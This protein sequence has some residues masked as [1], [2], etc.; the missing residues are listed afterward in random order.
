MKNNK[1]YEFTGKTA[2][3]GKHILHRIRALRDF[4]DVKA[5]DLGGFIESEG[6][7]SHDGECWV[8]HN[9]KVSG[10]GVVCDNGVVFGHGMVRDHGR[11]CDN[12]GVAGYGWVS[13]HGVVYGYGRLSGHGSVHDKND[14]ITI[15]PIGS[16]KNTTTFFKTQEGDI[17]VACGCFSGTLDEFKD[18]VR[19]KHN[20]NR[21]AKEYMKAIELAEI[22]ILGGD[23]EQ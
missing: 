4:G 15:C 21:Y 2:N 19:Q 7:L 14:I 10:N 11:V 16:R 17:G 18:R 1:K 12:G 3:V 9:G 23:D 5:G 8:Y 6:N 20:N 13:G 22:H